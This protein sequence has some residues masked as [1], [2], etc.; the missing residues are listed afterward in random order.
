MSLLTFPSNW[1][2]FW[3]VLGWAVLYGAVGV[4]LYDDVESPQT[5]DD[6][7]WSPGI[8]FGWPSLY[9]LVVHGLGLIE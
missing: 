8:L 5:F 4:L 3:V 6:S 2:V 1:D 9:W 7:R